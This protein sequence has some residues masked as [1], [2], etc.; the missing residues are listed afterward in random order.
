MKNLGI[1]IHIP[2]CVQ[3]CPY[4]GFLSAPPESDD[5]VENY[6]DHLIKE[7]GMAGGAYGEDRK[8]D[9]VFIGGGT[10]SLLSSEQIWCVVNALDAAFDMTD[11][12]EITIEANPG[13]LTHEKLSAYRDCGINRLSMGVQAMDD[14]L[15][16]SIGRIHRKEDVITG[17]DLARN[18]GFENINLDLMFGMP[19]QDMAMWEDTLGQII[20]MDPEHISF[21]SLQIEGNTPFYDLY[22]AGELDTASDETERRMHHKAI[23]TLE[24]AGFEHYEISNSAKPGRQCRHN[25]KYWSMD[26]YVGLGLGAHSYML[27]ESAGTKSGDDTGDSCELDDGK[28]D[29]RF[30]GGLRYNNT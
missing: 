11:D 5:E 29:S 23:H 17:Y 3:K 20:E 14:D 10:P 26:E 2:F 7:A 12:P 25:L 9:T 28:T 24:D 19:G 18:A 4:C 8:V 15:L 21:Y 30:T 27:T 16:W 13:T 22:K 1:Y 6:I